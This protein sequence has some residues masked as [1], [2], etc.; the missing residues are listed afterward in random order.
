MSKSLLVRFHGFGDFPNEATAFTTNVLPPYQVGIGV[1]AVVSVPDSFSSSVTPFEPVG[2]DP[3]VSISLLNTPDV[4]RILLSSALVPVKNPL[5][6]ETVR[7]RGYI[8]TTRPFTVEV[9]DSTPFLPLDAITIA[10]ER[11]IVT[12]VPTATSITID[13]ASESIPTPKAW[14][15][16]ATGVGGVPIYRSLPSLEG[17]FVSIAIIDDETTVVRA[18]EEIVLRGFVRGWSMDTSAGGPGLLKVSI[19]GLLAALST[20]VLTPPPVKVSNSETWA[21]R[22][23]NPFDMLYPSRLGGEAPD[24]CADGY[25]APS[26]I[27][28]VPKQG[29]LAGVW[30]FCRWG[31]EPPSSTT[32]TSRARF[33]SSAR[34]LALLDSHSPSGTGRG[35]PCLLARQRRRQ[36]LVKSPVTACKMHICKNCSIPLAADTG[37][38]FGSIPRRTPARSCS[39]TTGTGSST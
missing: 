32:P 26:F 15:S 7:T 37:T 18:D 22:D 35:P 5:T 8:P 33:W 16:I 12:A 4:R 36:P 23:V 24:V 1:K 10:N 13:T 38:I 3:S 31:R 30:S 28:V 21:T 14:S 39:P 9:T 6:G 34:P 20:R 11:L 19:G 25:T 17:A 29:A 2:S 27:Y